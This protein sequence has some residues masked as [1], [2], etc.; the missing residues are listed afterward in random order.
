MSFIEQQLATTRIDAFLGDAK[1]TTASMKKLKNQEPS[2]VRNIFKLT[3]V[4]LLVE[5]QYGGMTYSLK[6]DA[7]RNGEKKGSTYNGRRGDIQIFNSG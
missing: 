5:V 4:L 2:L 6:T 3:L 1:P 7:L